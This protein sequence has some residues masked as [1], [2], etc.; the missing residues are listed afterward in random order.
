MCMGPR[1]AGAAD[2][3]LVTAREVG[4]AEL[5][6]LP[7]VTRQGQGRGRAWSQKVCC[8]AQARVTSISSA[9]GDA[10]AVPTPTCSPR[11]CRSDSGATLTG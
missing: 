4:L 10:P 5:G 3:S 7:K 9:T 2:E 8:G 1:G 11:F 6:D